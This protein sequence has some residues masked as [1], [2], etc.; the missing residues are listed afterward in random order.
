MRREVRLVAQIQDADPAWVVVWR[1]VPAKHGLICY[2]AMQILGLRTRE[3][4]EE[5]LLP[6]ASAL[7][8][9]F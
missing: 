1:P 8:R 5:C 2:H 9:L 4:P 7:N 6:Q 3:V